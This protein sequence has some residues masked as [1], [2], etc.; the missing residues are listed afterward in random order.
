M[1]KQAYTKVRKITCKNQ[2]ANE[3]SRRFGAGWLMIL[4]IFNGLIALYG[5]GYV[6]G[7]YRLN[8]INNFHSTL[9]H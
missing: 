6:A 1:I 2:L 5:V 8:D 4:H 7:K 3:R 9:S